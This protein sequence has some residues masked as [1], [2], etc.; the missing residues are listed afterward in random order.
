M[1]NSHVNMLDEDDLK[2][3]LNRIPDIIKIYDLNHNICFLNEIGEKMYGKT[4]DE[5]KEDKSCKNTLTSEEKCT[6]FIIDRVIE[7]KKA[8]KQEKYISEL[9]KIMDCCYTPIYNNDGKLKFVLERLTDITEKKRLSI[10]LERDNRKYKKI[11][12][13]LPD[14]LMIVENEIIVQAN[15]KICDFIGK[16]YDEIINTNIFDYCGEK[17]K[18][19]LKK[20]MKDLIKNKKVCDIFD[21]EYKNSKGSIKFLQMVTSYLEYGGRPAMFILFR[22][23]TEVKVEL[24]KAALFQRNSLQK[25][26]ESNKFVDIE[27][28]YVPANIISGDFFRTCKIDNE[29]IVGIVID[30]KGKGI[31]AA[32]STSAIDILFLQ[33]IGKSIDPLTIVK[34]LNEKLVKYYGDTYIAV[35]VFSMNFNKKQLKVVGAGIN[36]FLYKPVHDNTC[37]K[38]VK[39]PFLGMFEDSEFDEETIH[40]K[41]GDKIILFTDGFDFVLEEKPSVKQDIDN[42]DMKKLKDDVVEYFQDEFLENGKLKDDC[43]MLLIEIK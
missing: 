37:E 34:N 2:Q 41:S 5:M 39:G 29:N 17:Y 21:C 4:F 30:V 40:F 24:K 11:I 9:D 19:Q 33:E 25:A 42:G 3:I 1:I 18:F 43:T 16:S 36:R 23:S 6:Q 20:K 15:N 35:C 31:S 10:E 22:D 14:A 7:E 32:L 28:I 27:R 12:N 26:I 38:I 13:D 8:I